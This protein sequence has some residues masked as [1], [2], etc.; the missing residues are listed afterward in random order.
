MSQQC[1]PKDSIAYCVVELNNAAMKYSYVQTR[2]CIP[3]TQKCTARFEHASD[4]RLPLLATPLPDQSPPYVDGWVAACAFES[5]YD[6]LGGGGYLVSPSSTRSILQSSLIAA[7]V[8]RTRSLPI[9]DP[10]SYCST[11]SIPNTSA[12]RLFMVV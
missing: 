4:A 5:C 9:D 11:L 7:W 6:R 1:Y 3:R 10:K 2:K 12:P 8:T